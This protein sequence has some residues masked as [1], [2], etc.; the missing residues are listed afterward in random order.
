LQKYQKKLGSAIS[1]F[2][3]LINQEAIDGWEFH[4]M[5]SIST[6]IKGGCLGGNGTT[7]TYNMLVFKKL[8]E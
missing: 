1:E 3:S 5:E 6:H 8:K 7:Q 2:A 4:S